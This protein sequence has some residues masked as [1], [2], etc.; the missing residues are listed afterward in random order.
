M[1][2]TNWTH[3]NDETKIKP[4]YVAYATFKNFIASMKDLVPARIDTTHPF[5]VGQSGSNQSYLISALRFFDLVNDRTPNPMLKKLAQSEG[6]ARK[7]LWKELF[8]RAYKPVLGDLDLTTST[9]GML[10]EKFR[11]QEL[12]G[13]TINK[14]FSFFVAGAEDA[15]LPMAQH[16]KPGVRTGASAGRRQRKQKNG[17]V[18]EVEGGE[19]DDLSLD[20]AGKQPIATLLLN[21]EGTR[22]VALS[23]PSTITKAEL[24]RIQKWLSFQLIVEDDA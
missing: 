24:D 8:E 14:C 5:M 7:N 12:T 11:A 21:K 2:R 9:A 23:A 4:P 15:G 10:H 6:D 3:M 22:K 1:R 19:N 13:E 18:K 17:G 20:S 16:L